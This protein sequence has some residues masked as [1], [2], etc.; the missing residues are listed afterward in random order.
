VAVTDTGIGIATADAFQ[1]FAPF[2]QLDTGYAPT[3]ARAREAT[4]LSPRRP[5]DPA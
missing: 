3:G 2:F 4:P 1:L 5:P